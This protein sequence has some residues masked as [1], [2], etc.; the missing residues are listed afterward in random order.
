MKIDLRSTRSL[1]LGCAL[2]GMPGIAAAQEPPNGD[3]E[4]GVLDPWF[5]SG[6][7]GVSQDNVLEGLWSGFLTT[8]PNAVGEVCSYLHS[9]DVFPPTDQ[10][11]AKVTFKVRYKSNEFTG[12]S[13]FFED[14]FHA[15]FVTARGALDLLTIK[16]DGI[17]WTKG[18]PTGTR[19]INEATGTKLQGPPQIPPFGP[20]AFFGSETPTLSASSEI[21]L[22]G[23]EPVRIKF[24]IC[25]WVDQIVDSAAYVDAV[26][27][28]F[29]K[30]GKECFDDD[31][32]TPGIQGVQGV[33]GIPVR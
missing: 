28:S 10:A 11:R 22:K 20:G 8:G 17:F 5:G 24:E 9:P 21:K 1:V 6:D 16:T 15:E 3:F 25:D 30:K 4:A 26:T 18:D 2:A 23:C 33:Q 7:I 14:P 32:N 13:A 27:I 12:P 31:L 29:K 19:V